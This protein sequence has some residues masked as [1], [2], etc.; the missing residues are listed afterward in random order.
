MQLSFIFQRFCRFFDSLDAGLVVNMPMPVGFPYQAGCLGLPEC[1]ECPHV[2][3]FAYGGDRQYSWIVL[4][5]FLDGI[6]AMLGEYVKFSFTL[7]YGGLDV[8]C[9]YFCSSQ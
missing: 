3:F 2:V 5:S 6:A 4:L 7:G 8:G 9:C 1:F